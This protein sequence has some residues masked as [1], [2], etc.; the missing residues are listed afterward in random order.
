MT[1]QEKKP[2]VE[3]ELDEKHLEFNFNDLDQAVEQA[4]DKKKEEVGLLAKVDWPEIMKSIA[5]LEQG[6]SAV[7][8]KD[9]EDAQNQLLGTVTEAEEVFESKHQEII[10]E[11]E[12]KDIEPLSV[13]SKLSQAEEVL[14]EKS[15]RGESPIANSVESEILSGQDTSVEVEKTGGSEVQKEISTEPP[16]ELSSKNKSLYERLSDKAKTVAIEAFKT[17]DISVG[18]RIR[19]S[20]GKYLYWWHNKKLDKLQKEGDD[21]DRQIG[22]LSEKLKKFDNAI[23]QVESE[24]NP[25]ELEKI[26]EDRE[27]LASRL[28]GLET[29]KTDQE[30]LISEQA[31]KRDGLKGDLDEIFKEYHNKIAKKQEPY[32]EQLNQL[33][34]TLS[35]LEADKIGYES[36]LAEFEARKAKL[37]GQL[38]N[39]TNLGLSKRDIKATSKVLKS[40]IIQINK[41]IK[42]GE[43]EVS[44][45]SKGIA[46]ITKQQEV[47][48]AKVKNW[49]ETMAVLSEWGSIDQIE[50]VPIKTPEIR[51]T[52]ETSTPGFYENNVEISADKFPINGYITRWNL[53]SQSDGLAIKLEDFKKN[54]SIS[55]LT[56]KQV[57]SIISKM[58]FSQSRVPRYQLKNRLQNKMDTMRIIFKNYK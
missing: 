45:L 57:E 53:I 39:L 3:S 9:V 5:G 25:K 55:E 24:L 26:K 19:L 52:P 46:K 54:Q 51:P 22:D 1:D 6:Q 20:A 44:K 58:P 50:E 42:K 41:E 48:T 43:L 40:T 23:S 11:R 17:V 34:E 2:L 18:G 7:I 49:K 15:V 4:I 37:V 27:K 31:K 28:T 16:V 36:N 12:T 38:E 8:E 33:N 13:E 32:Q 21:F 30:I 14:G 47:P 10:N 29:Q 35:S 56:L